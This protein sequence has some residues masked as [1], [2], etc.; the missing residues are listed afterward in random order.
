MRL[1]VLLLAVVLLPL[2]AC[3]K[4]AATTAPSAATGPSASTGPVTN[5]AHDDN[6]YAEPDKVVVTHLALELAIDFDKLTL[7]SQKLYDE[8]VK[9][10]GMYTARLGTTLAFG[11]CPC[12][13]SG[14]LGVGSGV[15]VGIKI[16]P[17][18]IIVPMSEAPEEEF[19]AVYDKFIS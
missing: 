11:I 6:S 4:P 18:P 5:Q 14:K 2:A 3:Q 1:I 7:E 13:K 15:D 17:L 10:A 19:M 8:L 9:K 16:V 12:E